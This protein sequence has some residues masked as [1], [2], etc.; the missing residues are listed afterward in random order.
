MERVIRACEEM[1][2]NSQTSSRA[3]PGDEERGALEHLYRFFDRP[4]F[5]HP[6]HYECDLKAFDRAMEDTIQG[7]NTGILRTRRGDLIAKTL[8]RHDFH[9]PSWRKALGDVEQLIGEIR[10][11]FAVAVGVGI[12]RS[13]TNGLTFSTYEGDGLMLIRSMNGLRNDAIT[14]VNSLFTEAGKEAL[15]LIAEPHG[16]WMEAKQIFRMRGEGEFD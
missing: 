9:N 2:P 1:R 11:R 15:P 3:K 10:Q 12:L 4:A 8:S 16:G 7:L 13:L 6:F 14:L 5:H